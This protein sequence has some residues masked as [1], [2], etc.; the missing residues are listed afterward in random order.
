MTSYSSLYCSVMFCIDYY[1]ARV[2]AKGN[3]I[4]LTG[5]DNKSCHSENLGIL[6]ESMPHFSFS[7]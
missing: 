5:N 4:I 1:P 3:V 6:H 2:C 7:F